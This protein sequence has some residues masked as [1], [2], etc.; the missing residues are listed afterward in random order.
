MRRRVIQALALAVTVCIAAPARADYTAT[1]DPS[2]QYGIWQG[3]GSSLAWWANVVGGFPEAARQDYMEKAFD[4]VKGLG[5]NIVRYNIGGGENPEH[6]APNRQFLS[7][8]AAV[9]GYEP[10]PGRWD[11]SADTNQR[12][13]LQQAIKRGAN[14]LEVFSNSPPWWMTVSGSVT[15]NHGGADNLKPDADGVFADYL[16]AVVQHFHDAW[17][18]TFRDV[19]PLNEPSGG[20]SF[21]NYQEGCHVDRPHQ[22]RMVNAVGAALARRGMTY[23]TATASDEPS[24]GD[25]DRTFPVYDAT[26]LRALTKINTHSYG[27]GDRTQLFDF[28]NSAGKDLWLSEDGDGDASGL[29]MSRQILTDV[30]GLHSSAWVYWQ[31][32]DSAGGWGFLKNPL[33][34]EEHTAYTVNGK[35]YVMGQYSKFIRPGYAIIAV[36]D[37]NSLAAYDARAKTLAIVT[38]NSGDTDTRVAFDLSKFTRLGP[39]VTAYRTSPTESWAKLPRI[40]LTGGR[41]SVTAPAKSVTTYVIGGAVY[42]GKIGINFRDYYR[43]VNAGSGLDLGGAS[44]QWTLIGQGNGFYKVVNRA[45]GLVLDVDRA[46]K[47]AGADVIQYGDNG[48]DNQ[49]WNLADAGGGTLT[50]VNRNSGLALDGTRAGVVQQPGNTT[51]GQRWRLVRVSAEARERP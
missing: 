21:G 6:L 12:W 2:I 29:R 20:W 49:L 31:V 4:P 37:S 10:A 39:S 44:Q 9:P 51:A 47:T 1:V 24:I 35:Y 23:T 17:G 33:D 34:S 42:A 30:R 26:A 18:I 8:R 27:G 11:W 15:G 14:Q 19:E 28:A 46:A 50:L 25:A 41:F 16:T 7:F 36:D 5:L 22:N 45:S 48:G 13:V 32:V 3:W 43:L 40:P 38:T